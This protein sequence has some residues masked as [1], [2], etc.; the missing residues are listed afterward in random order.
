MKKF[1]IDF[2]KWHS[3]LIAGVFIDRAIETLQKPVSVEGLDTLYVAASGK[4]LATVLEE[5]F[6]N[7]PQV[8][9]L[10]SILREEPSDWTFAHDDVTARLNAYKT[11]IKM[12]RA[13]QA[14]YQQEQFTSTAK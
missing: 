7:Q 13:V 5:F 3:K 11:T 2:T 14:Q 4:T 6:P 10:T 12:L 9:H 8:Y 1:E